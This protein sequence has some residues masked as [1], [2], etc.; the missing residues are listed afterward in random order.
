MLVFNESR[1]VVQKGQALLGARFFRQRYRRDITTLLNGKSD[2]SVRKS[3]FLWTYAYTTL[4]Q[5]DTQSRQS[6]TRTCKAVPALK[7]KRPGL[8]KSGPC[9]GKRKTV[10]TNRGVA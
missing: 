4:L 3:L 10:L 6:G 8:R 1:I 9:L 5:D 2:I 7:Q